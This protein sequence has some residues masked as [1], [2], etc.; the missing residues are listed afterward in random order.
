MILRKLKKGMS[1]EKKTLNFWTKYR[2][3]NHSG[4]SGEKIGQKLMPIEYKEV[5]KDLQFGPTQFA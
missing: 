5:D 2:N 3:F 1:N 4:Q